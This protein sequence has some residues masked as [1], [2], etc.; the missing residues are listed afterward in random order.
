[1]GSRGG[2]PMI[3]REDGRA[4]SRSRPVSATPR[5]GLLLALWVTAAAA[6]DDACTAIDIRFLAAPTRICLLLLRASLAV[7]YFAM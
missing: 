5:V 6:Q 4:D 2:G 3:G 1:M 7:E